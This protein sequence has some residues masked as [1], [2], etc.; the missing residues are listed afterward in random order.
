GYFI[1]G[2]FTTGAPLQC[3]GL[4]VQHYTPELLSETFGEEFELKQHQSEIH[5]TPSGVEQAYVYCMF[6]RTS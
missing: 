5:K 4:P 6:Q 2:T 1:I 3:S